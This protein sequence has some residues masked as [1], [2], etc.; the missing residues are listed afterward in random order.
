MK[1]DERMSF[2]MSCSLIC[3][4]RGWVGRGSLSFFFSGFS[5]LRSL[6]WLTPIFSAHVNGGRCKWFGGGGVHP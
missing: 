5:H 6:C 1:T 4:R 3:K 2:H